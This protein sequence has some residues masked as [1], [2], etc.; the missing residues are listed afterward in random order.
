MDGCETT[1][2]PVDEAADIHLI[3]RLGVGK[4]LCA[5]DN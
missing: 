5:V 4:P 2:E 1:P 3:G